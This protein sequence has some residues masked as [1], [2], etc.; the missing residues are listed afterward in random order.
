MYPMYP[1]NNNNNYIRDKLHKLMS[2]S[3]KIFKTNQEIK[4]QQDRLTQLKQQLHSHQNESDQLVQCIEVQSQQFQPIQNQILQTAP[5]YSFNH[6]DLIPVQNQ[7]PPEFMNGPNH[8]LQ[9]MPGLNQTE[10][11]VG[12][13]QSSLGQNQPPPSELIMNR[14][15]QSNQPEYVNGRNQPSGQ[16]QFPP[17]EVIMN[18]P[19]QSSSNSMLEQNQPEYVNGRNQSS[20]QNQISSPEFI[21]NRQSQSNQPEYVNGRNLSSGQ[22]QISPPEFIMNRQSQSNQPEYVN[23]RNLSSGQNQFSPPEVIMNRPIQ[24]SSNSM[25]EQNQPEYVDGRN[26]SPPGQNQFSPPEF[27]VN[28]QSQS[29]SLPSNSIPEQ[30]KSVDGRNQSSS[31]PPDFNVEQNQSQRTHNQFMAEQNSNQSVSQ[32]PDYAFDMNSGNSY[33]FSPSQDHLSPAVNPEVVN[34]GTEFY[35]ANSQNSGG[36]TNDHVYKNK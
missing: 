4:L 11:M 9:S 27:I 18:R 12:Q 26:Q 28:Q 3:V 13:S 2:T 24:P 6:T 36:G 23:G 34:S 29:S 16:N 22:N 19:I 25:P 8:T 14:Q 33:P 21:M 32:S 1:N 31:I 17:P 7:Y 15:I 20:G 30:N 10:V 5:I 35:S